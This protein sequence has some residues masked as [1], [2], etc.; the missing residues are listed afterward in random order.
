MG[1][2]TVFGQL[3]TFILALLFGVAYS[4]LYDIFKTFHL[5]IFTGFW[6]VFISDILYW[7]ILLVCT[8]SFLL[9][10]CNG[11]VRA[12]VL[13]GNVVG[14]ALCR[15]TLS[16]IFIKICFLTIFIIEKIIQY[17]KLPI[18]ILCRFMSKLYEKAVEFSKKIVKNLFKKRKKHLERDNIN[19]V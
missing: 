7:F 1:T 17:I 2:I 5:K 13:F 9:I 15:F 6:S 4:L 18:G 16:K 12:Y 19:G 14:F 3:T 10:F 8:Y 11:I